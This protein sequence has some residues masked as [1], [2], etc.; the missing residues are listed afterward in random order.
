M[1]YLRQNR[2][3]HL[4]YEQLWNLGAYRDLY[5]TKIFFSAT[6]NVI[7]DRLQELQN[8]NVDYLLMEKGWDITNQYLDD[9]KII[10]RLF[11]TK[12]SVKPYR[13]SCKM[14][15]ATN[16]YIK[17]NYVLDQTNDDW[18]LYKRKKLSK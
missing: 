10:N 12:Y 17:S 4:Y 7:D 3:D 13:Y 14:F 2:I 8:L 15:D 9:N 5:F 6:Q 16:H 18:C 1:P 11:Q